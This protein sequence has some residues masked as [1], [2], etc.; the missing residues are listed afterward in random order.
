MKDKEEYFESMPKYV[1]ETDTAGNY[2]TDYNRVTLVCK[3]SKIRR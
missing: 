1:Q 3:T 2:Y